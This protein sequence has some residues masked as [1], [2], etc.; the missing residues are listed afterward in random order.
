MKTWQD[1]INQARTQA[2]KRGFF[3]R[4]L[5]LGLDDRLLLLG[6]TGFSAD[7]LAMAWDW[8]TCPFGEAT[9]VLGLRVE[10]LPNSHMNNGIPPRDEMLRALGKSFFAAVRDNR[11]DKAEA[12]YHAIIRRARELDPHASEHEVDAVLD[13]IAAQ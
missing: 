7:D 10:M 9:N 8:G 4:L 1:R 12:L 6:P 13:Q 11:V 3:R 2:P 5:L